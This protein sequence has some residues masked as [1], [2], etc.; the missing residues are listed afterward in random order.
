MGHDLRR[1]LALLALFPALLLTASCAAGDAK[2]D[3]KPSAGAGGATS[4]GGA[5]SPDKAVRE[6]VR[7]LEAGDCV[8][9][10]KIVLQPSAVDCGTVSE[11]EGT[12]ADDG[13]TLS[14]VRYTAGQ[15]VGGSAKVAVRW[16]NGDP[17]ESFDVQKVDDL[18]L[19]LF[20]SAA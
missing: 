16:G 7:A 17:A 18:W 14:T 3:S 15:V 12:F 2:D 8:A 11:T 20:D 10:K 4:A 9:V 19:V 13:I 6:L 5:A 1:A